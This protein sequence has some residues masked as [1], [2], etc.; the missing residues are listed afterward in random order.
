MERA[1]GTLESSLQVAPPSLELI[2]AVSHEINAHRLS[3]GLVLVAESMP[4]LESAA[5]TLLVP[6]GHS[7]DPADRLGLGNFTCEMVQRGCGERDS[8]QFIEDLERLGVDTSGSVLTAH[9]NF[10]AA[11]PAERLPAA[12]AIHA[13][14]VRRPLLPESQLEDAR[15]VCLQEIR[16]AEDDLAQQVMN[17]LRHRRYGEPF[18]RADYG[19]QPGVTAIGMDDIR[20]SVQQFFQ[21]QG[22]ILGVAGKIDWPQLRADVERLFGDWQSHAVPALTCTPPARGY[23]HIPYDSSQTHIGI[24]FDSVPYPHPDYFK[25]RAAVGI[26]SDGVS[27]R[28]FTEVRE[29]RGLVY[30]V[31]AS[32]HSL[33]DRGS[34]NCYAGTTTERAQETLN[35]VLTELTRLADGVQE[36]ELQR[37]KARIKSSLIMQQE[38]STSR[39]SSLAFDWYYLERI[40][41]LDELRAVIDQLT[42]DQINHYLAENPPRQF[43]AVTLGQQPL[44]TPVEI[45]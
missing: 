5:F 15:A 44:E 28:L 17:E 6:A 37:L 29:K 30:T 40:R 21:P 1:K 14:L 19:T 26:L 45:S 22:A 27:S 11:M 13:D 25:A 2:V 3:N 4:W 24:S 31:S 23:R 36:E 43:N 8:R 35:V 7:R 38:S 10:G 33:K 12:L 32:C 16:A 39:S 41:P 18:G 34:V 42:A 20:R 9:T